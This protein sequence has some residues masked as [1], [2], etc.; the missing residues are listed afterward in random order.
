MP[1][2][3]FLHVV[4]NPWAHIDSDGQNYARP[5]GK[6][7]HY[8]T[9]PGVSNAHHDLVGA[10]IAHVETLSPAQVRTIGNLTMVGRHAQ[11]RHVIEYERGPTR[12]MNEKH[13]QDEVRAG[14][15]IAYDLPSA[16]A[17]GIP[18]DEFVAPEKLLAEFRD[19]A[20]KQFYLE[21][22]NA[23]EVSDVLYAEE[24]PAPAQPAAEDQPVAPPSAPAPSDV[25]TSAPAEH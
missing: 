17:C 9:G 21:N 8:Y 20:I 7:L 11:E 22:P 5:C 3:R 18:A 10:R 6:V 25:V 24:A 4:P 15:L 14:N 12:V 13:Y 19:V 1:K 2:E 16:V 23:P